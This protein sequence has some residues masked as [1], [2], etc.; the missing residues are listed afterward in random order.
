M[1]VSA[2]ENFLRSY[3]AREMPRYTVAQVARYLRVPERTVRAWFYG[4]SYGRRPHL[5]RF[6][7]IL[8]PA[9]KDLLSFYD[10]ASAHVLLAFKA[11]KIPTTDIRAIVQT[12]QCRLPDNLYP[13]LGV[14]FYRF[15]RSVIVKEAGERLNL[16]RGGQLG[17]RHVVD[18]F[19][20]RL[21][22]DDARMPV[23]FFPIINV[24]K[25]ARAFIVIDPNL[26][27][28]RPVMKGT[29][30]AAEVIAERRN[31]GESVA[32]LSRDY[33]LSRRAIQEAVNYF[34]QQAA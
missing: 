9:G 34:R 12:L 18:K 7:P 15:G 22:T 5:R 31:S 28:G 11:K 10:A 19:L 32:S 6:N 4:T 24:N 23:R 33:R 1:S 16:S 14:A 26:S 8:N 27:G 17:F 30:V 25:R 3:D 29:G 13:L 21:E 2:A 20:R